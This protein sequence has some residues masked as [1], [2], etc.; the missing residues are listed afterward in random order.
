VKAVDRGT[1][2][3]QAATPKWIDEFVRERGLANP[4]DAVDG[5]SDGVRAP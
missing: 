3:R 2:H 1:D 4:V 5:D